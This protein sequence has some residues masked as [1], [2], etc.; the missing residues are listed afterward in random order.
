MTLCYYQHRPWPDPQC[1]GGVGRCGKGGDL[2]YTPICH[3]GHTQALLRQIMACG[4][5]ATHW[6]WTV[7]FAVNNNVSFSMGD[8]LEEM[9]IR[10]VVAQFGFLFGKLL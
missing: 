6:L 9:L 4:A 10:H 3:D 8:Q 1:S 5:I 2:A 7:N